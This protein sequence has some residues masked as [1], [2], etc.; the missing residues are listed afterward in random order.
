MRGYM[1]K[2][3]MI[4]LTILSVTCIYNTMKAS[5]VSSISTDTLNLLAQNNSSDK[6]V[7]LIAA[8]GLG[9]DCNHASTTINGTNYYENIEARK[10]VNR[11]AGY[12]EDLGINYEIANQIIGDAYWSNDPATR[13]A[14]RNCTNPNTNSCCGF[15]T[16]SIGTYSPT[17]MNHV[18][19]RGI[20]NYSLVLEVHFNGGGGNYSVVFGRDNTTEAAGLELAQDVAD[21]IGVGYGQYKRDTDSGATSVGSLG[22]ISNFYA[23]RSIPVYYLET[24][25]MDNQEQFISY[26]DNQSEVAQTIANFIAEKAPGAKNDGTGSMYVGGGRTVD[27]YPNVFANIDVFTQNSEGCG[28]IFIDEFGNYTQLH[29]FMEEIFTLIK[30]ATPIIVIALSTFD[31]IKAITS[32]NADEMKKANGRTIKRIV[33][34]L[35]IFFLPYLLEILFKLFGLYDISTCGIGE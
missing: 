12:L 11:I 5:K 1:K 32:S 6:T 33:I 27:P 21:A 35:L 17:L 10:L 8:H 28:T 2:M 9:K 13:N 31:Y 16:A 19:E 34:G 26:L 4:L 30:I 22:T 3:I 20:E 29:E 25:F 18:D 14:A 15:R 23:N 7:L 24:A